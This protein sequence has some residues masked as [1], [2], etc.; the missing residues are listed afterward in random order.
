MIFYRVVENENYNKYKKYGGQ[1][2]D[3]PT[4]IELI[5]PRNA[6]IIRNFHDATKLL[7]RAIRI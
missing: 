2:W 4:E 6:E 5:F 3:W 1:T 7:Q